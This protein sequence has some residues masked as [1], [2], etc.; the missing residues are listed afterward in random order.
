MKKFPSYHRSNFL[1]RRGMSSQRA[2][3]PLAKDGQSA[4]MPLAVKTLHEV[5]SP[6]SQEG[7]MYGSPFHALRHSSR[8]SGD[9]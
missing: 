1:Y 4:V 5:C 3:L 6:Q 8:S 7:V 2:P 9:L